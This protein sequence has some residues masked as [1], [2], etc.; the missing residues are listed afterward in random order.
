M[1]NTHL[2]TPDIFLLN[3]WSQQE[4]K[5]TG[6]A[7]RHFQFLLIALI[8]L[9]PVV[10][11]MGINEAFDARLGSAVYRTDCS[12][13]ITSYSAPIFAYILL[14]LL[15]IIYFARKSREIGLGRTEARY[16]VQL[17]I[18]TSIYFSLWIG[19]QFVVSN[20]MFSISIRCFGM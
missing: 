18:F 8:V 2:A 4:R 14:V 15:L 16:A 19:S 1:S 17:C 6:H 3:S 7:S 20:P 10:I 11:I 9:L 12:L 5:D 13:N